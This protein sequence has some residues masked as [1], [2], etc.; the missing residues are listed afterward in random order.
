MNLV[1]FL[2]ALELGLIYGLVAIGVYLTF[3]VI[4]FPDLTVDGTFPMG[5]AIASAMIVGGINPYLATLI[6]F[7]GG[8]A[9]G[10]MTA[11]LHVRWKIL[12]LL[13][14]IL[15]M[16][17]LYSIN[18]RIM[19]RPNIPLLSDDTIFTPF[20]SEF[21]VLGGVTLLVVFA[22][23]Y[24]LNSE[25]GLGVRATGVNP[26]VARAQGVRVRW[27]IV[28]TLALSNGIVAVAGA[29]FAQA[30]GFADVSLGV[31]TIIIGLASV[32][33]GEAIFR[34]RVIGWLIF[35]CVA[36]SI[37]Y[38]VAIA[39][40]LNVGGFG[41]KASDLKLITALLIALTMIIP[42]IKKRS[43]RTRKGEVVK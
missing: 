28:L 37:I 10:C 18:L 9:A 43:L 3:R 11:Y 1:Q 19:G 34:T 23:V 39:L 15:T 38:R 6:A 24:F 29:L 26:Q 35:G 7:F 17:G 42:K 20:N 32:I 27:M 25:V 14:G 5:A 31:G 12:G 30:Q 21:W 13:A 40:A 33:V 2:G 8:A 16:T 41:L 36:G 4:D 22:I